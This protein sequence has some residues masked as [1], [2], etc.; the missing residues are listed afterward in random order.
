MSKYASL[1][2]LAYKRPQLLHECLESLFK[3]LDYPAQV[4]IN[5]DSAVENHLNLEIISYLEGRFKNGEISNLIFNQGK[6]RGVG[7]SFKNCLGLA[8]GDY[9]FKVDT[10]I[11]FRPHWLSKAVSI[12]ESNPEIGSLGL[13]D[14]HRQDPTDSRFKPDFN[15]IG[16]TKDCARVK[17]YVSSIYGFR[18]QDLNLK[19]LEEVPDDGLHQSF[20]GSL[21]LI[22]L[23]NV[24]AWGVGNSTYVSGTMDHPKKTETFNEPLILQPSQ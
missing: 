15:I 19:L 1:C 12:L 11:I 22:D 9:I 16:Y 2:I 17:D 24:K 4:I 21:G 5:L 8:E 13:F 14:Y 6:N 7:R 3:T 18:R 23:V 20:H 10:D